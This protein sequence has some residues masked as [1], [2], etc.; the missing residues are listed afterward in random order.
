LF[1]A[2]AR[3][4]AL[5]RARATVLSFALVGVAL[6]LG[7]C[8]EPKP[9][10]FDRKV[11]VKPDEVVLFSYGFRVLEGPARVRFR[12]DLESGYPFNTSIMPRP[13]RD[14]KPTEASYKRAYETVLST[15]S[16]TLDV[17]L[18]PGVYEAVVTP[19]RRESSHTVRVRFNLQPI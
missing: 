13:K 4:S 9:I 10:S 6:C 18:E 7:S 19:T 12:V 2:S 3:H 14:E 17:T 1:I 5:R 11:S 8:N 16:V 15:R